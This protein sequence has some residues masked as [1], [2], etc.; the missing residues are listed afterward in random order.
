MPDYY[1]LL[2][3]SRDAPTSEI[4]DAY[5]ALIDQAR[6]GTTGK[7][8]VAVTADPAELNQAWNVL[9]DPFQRRR[10]DEQLR[11]EQREADPEAAPPAPP[12]RTKGRRPPVAKSAP[13]TD[14]AAEAAEP[15]PP[16]TILGALKQGS[17]GQSERKKVEPIVLPRGLTVA[18]RGRRIAATAIDLVTALVAYIA[19]EFVLYFANLPGAAALAVFYGGLAALIVFYALA[20]VARSGQT[21]G[22]RIIHLRVADVTTGG[23]PGWVGSLRRY[24]API[25]ITVAIPNFGGFVALFLGFTFL[26]DPNHRSLLD[27]FARTVVVDA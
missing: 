22:K 4:K 17:R 25:L 9:A 10:Y 13:A 20:P 3:V 7:K 14:E 8:P 12:A 16:R 21:P 23:A 27:K 18:P 6:N 2:G 5:R 24:G 15:A 19:L 26:S 11:T 1:E